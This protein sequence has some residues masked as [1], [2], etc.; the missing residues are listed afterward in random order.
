[1]YNIIIRRKR[2]KN[3]KLSSGKKQTEITFNQYTLH[4]KMK[5]FTKDF[6]SKCDKKCRKL[7]RWS[8][9]LKKFLMENFIFSCRD[10]VTLAPSIVCLVFFL[11]LFGTR[12]LFS[13]QKVFV[14][15]L[16]RLGFFYQS[17]SF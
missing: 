1:M 2:R 15:F 13:T 3:L 17:A 16:E 14:E 4:K 12:I 8:H 5:F 6:V 11:S 7:Q 9:L 10:N